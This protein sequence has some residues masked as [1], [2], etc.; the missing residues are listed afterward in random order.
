MRHIG[1]H[2]SNNEPIFEGDTLEITKPED[3][4]FS[5]DF[6]ESLKIDRLTID[7]ATLHNEVGVELHYHFWSKGYIVLN[8]H[9]AAYLRSNRVTEEAIS[10]QFSG[11]S[12]E[13]PVCTII[14]SWHNSSSFYH[15]FVH[16][17]S[18]TIISKTAVKD[19]DAT[20]V[21]P[22]DLQITV[23]GIRHKASE[24]KFLVELTP[25]ALTLAKVSHISLYG[26]LDKDD[27]LSMRTDGNFTHILIKPKNI[28]LHE[29]ELEA[30]P[31]NEKREHT[32]YKIEHCSKKYREI[33]APIKARWK[34]K[35]KVWEAE[36]QHLSEDEI[37]GHKQSM[38]E[39][40]RAEFS[41]LEKSPLT[42]VK[43]LCT[44][45]FMGLNSSKNL[46][47]FFEDENCKVTPLLS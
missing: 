15:G 39:E 36:N 44:D 12:M 5:E 24:A 26:E 37:E 22:S 17:K 18:K 25:R 9:Y 1:I 35:I 6:I 8:S 27:N 46:F 45:L 10:D 29:Y 7:V 34:E 11:K 2:D 14:Q 31:V 23:D 13:E 19:R 41:P 21:S 30:E 16:R 20:A 38:W 43:T 3:I 4:S 47:V 32:W 28:S 42:E 33:A 40:A